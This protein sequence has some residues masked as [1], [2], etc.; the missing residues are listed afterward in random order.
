MDQC[1][2]TGSRL[3]VSQYL[4]PDVDDVTYNQTSTAGATFNIDRVA[5]GGRLNSYGKCQYGGKTT[6]S[7]NRMYIG[8]IGELLVF[9]RALTADEQAIVQAYLKR[10]WF[11]DTTVAGASAPVSE[12]GEATTLDVPS[13]AA[14]LAGTWTAVNEH[15]DAPAFA[16]TGAGT[17]NLRA[18]TAGGGIVKVDAGTLE[19]SGRTV[20]SRADVWLDAADESTVTVV[21]GKATSVANKG[22]SGGA[23][24]TCPGRWDSNVP[25]PVYEAAGIAGRNALG[26]D[27][28]AGLSLNSYTNESLGLQLHVYMVMQRTNHEEKEGFGK[29][30]GPYSFIDTSA[31]GDDQTVPTASHQEI[32]STNKVSVYVCGSSGAHT[33]PEGRL[34][35]PHLF[36]QHQLISRALTAYEWADSETADIVRILQSNGD[37]MPT[38]KINRILL[39]GRGTTGGRMQ[40]GS[41]GA[42]SN[43]TWA[44]RIGE[45]IMFTHPLSV[46]EE[47]ALLAYLRVKWLGKGEGSAT[48]P[49]FLSGDYPP[50]SL[51]GLG[52]ALADGVALEQA[53]PMCALASLAVGDDVAFTRDWTGGPTGFA[54]FD[55]AGA[56]SFGARPTLNVVTSPGETVQLF[57]GAYTGELP[58][59]TVTGDKANTSRVTLRT[60]GIYLSIGA[61]TMV[62]IR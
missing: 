48:P 25:Y 39:G 36:V 31:V 12:M 16:K 44:G 30:G 40:W 57:G 23:F 46:P 2:Y 61:G 24:G 37:G 45:V 47:T 60:D 52:L 49:A 10:K 7:E 17:L 33:F 59:W 6:G 41:K 35:Q 20:A 34:E 1:V 5:V 13:G 21:D 18:A 58:E 62:F 54:L 42:S 11:A 22:R 3:F 51:D 53:G 14:A 32:T 43:R 8:H 56:L 26:F 19:L 50:P 15:G 28:N 9:T 55:V 27:F 4:G 38:N 29:W